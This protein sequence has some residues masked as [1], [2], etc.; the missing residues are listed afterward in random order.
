[1]GQLDQIT[2]APSRPC[3]QE[4]YPPAPTWYDVGIATIF[5]S[6]ETIETVPMGILPMSPSPKLELPY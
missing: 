6:P 2:S 5:V 3:M 4:F 1:M